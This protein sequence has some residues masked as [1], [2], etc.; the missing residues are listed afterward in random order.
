MERVDRAMC[1][2]CRGN[3]HG[4][5]FIFWLEALFFEGEKKRSEIPAHRTSSPGRCWLLLFLYSWLGSG[6]S[7]AAF[8]PLVYS[9]SLGLNRFQ[10]GFASFRPLVSL[11]NQS[12][13]NG[14]V[15][16]VRTGLSSPLTH[17]VRGVGELSGAAGVTVMQASSGLIG[18]PA[19]FLV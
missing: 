9:L 6:R 2:S 11:R 17:A 4:G 16:L 19:P 1:R 12:G 3:K 8:V 10:F 15:L 13:F 5:R 14:P 18:P 7:Q